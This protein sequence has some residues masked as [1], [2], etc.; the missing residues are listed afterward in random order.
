MKKVSLVFVLVLALILT[1]FGVAAAPPPPPAPNVTFTVL[2]PLP[3]T[4]TVGQ[5]YAFIIEVTSDTPVTSVTAMPTY[6]FPGRYVTAV[7][8]NDR[9]GAGTSAILT[10]TFQA[11]DP[12]SEGNAGGAP[13]PVSIIV[14]ARFKGGVVV[15]QQYDYYITVQ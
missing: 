5:T 12:S 14:G 15:P 11:K 13:A 9:A 2:Q 1:L 8:G 4:M 6:F 3:D 10:I 7:K